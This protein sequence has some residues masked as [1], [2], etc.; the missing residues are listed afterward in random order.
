VKLL[1]ATIEHKRQY[2]QN[3]DALRFWFEAGTS[4]NKKKYCLPL[5]LLT[6]KAA[7]YQSEK[8][9]IAS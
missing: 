5:G 6:E 1:K 3:V 7:P 9:V 2:S 4:E 8:I